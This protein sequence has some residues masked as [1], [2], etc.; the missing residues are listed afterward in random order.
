MTVNSHTY[1]HRNK[2]KTTHNYSTLEWHHPGPWAPKQPHRHTSSLVGNKNRPFLGKAR[3]YNSHYNHTY[4]LCAVY[5]LSL[6]LSLSLSFSF[7][8]IGA[9]CITIIGGCHGAV[10]CLGQILH[11]LYMHV[12]GSSE[13]SPSTTNPKP[14]GNHPSTCSDTAV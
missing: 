8:S 3:T 7:S 9:L 5:R 1:T 12:H 10:G 13:G 14:R 11:V 6:S 2:R 4:M